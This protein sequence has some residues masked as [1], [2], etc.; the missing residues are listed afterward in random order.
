MYK[1]TLLSAYRASPDPH[2]V[3]QLRVTVALPHCAGDY[4][5]AA[6]LSLGADLQHPIVGLLL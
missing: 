6:F 2:L 1:W 3:G 4:K 5:I